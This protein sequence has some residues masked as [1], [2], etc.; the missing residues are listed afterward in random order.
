MNDLTLTVAL[1]RKLLGSL[2]CLDYCFDMLS[3]DVCT[4]RYR[5]TSGR[6][7]QELN[8]SNVAPQGSIERRKKYTIC[9]S[10]GIKCRH[11]IPYLY[12]VVAKMV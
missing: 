4:T 11:C 5:Q 2:M 8:V 1:I 7:V 3:M 10:A 12:I 6:L 9:I